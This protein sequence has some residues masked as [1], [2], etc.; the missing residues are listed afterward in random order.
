M[1]GVERGPTGE[2]PGVDLVGAGR[3]DQQ[4]QYQHRSSIEE[5]DSGY[6]IR[7]GVQLVL[8]VDENP[9]NR[10]VETT[11]EINLNAPFDVYEA[12]RRSAKRKTPPP[13]VSSTYQNLAIHSD[14]PKVKRTRFKGSYEYCS[15]AQKEISE[16]YKATDQEVPV[17]DVN[18][19]VGNSREVEEGDFGGMTTGKDD[20]A[21]L[22]EVGR[23]EEL[24]NLENGYYVSSNMILRD[25]V[26]V[27]PWKRVKGELTSA[28]VIASAKTN[29]TTICKTVQRG[30]KTRGGSESAT[31]ITI[32]VFLDF[33]GN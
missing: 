24:T 33:V 2:R 7:S 8:P 28:T 10:P 29:K 31:A 25:L 30:T 18:A 17:W 13:L 23:G 22:G 14:G 9:A 15:S 11:E 26:S 6:A 3:M 19:S 21:N 20:Y 1:Q 16:T 12:H 27:V 5:S 4:L 32:S